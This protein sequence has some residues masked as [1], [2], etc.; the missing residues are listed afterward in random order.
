MIKKIIK[1]ICAIPHVTMNYISIKNKRI[2]Y[3]DNFTIKGRAYF[4]G[5]GKFVF[6]ND[7]IINSSP[8]INPTA[9]GIN[10]HFNVGGKGVLQVG[11]NVG[12]SHCAITAI[13]SVV[14]EDNVMIGSNCMITDT[15]FHSISE[16]DVKIRPVLIKKGAFIGARCIILKGVVIGENAVVGAGSVVTKSI[17]DGEVWAGNPARFIKRI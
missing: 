9:G 6:G 4:H 17:P 12:I 10:C 11:N 5:N 16:E 8:N 13:E 14:I 15:D 2:V 1:N 7:V 3:G